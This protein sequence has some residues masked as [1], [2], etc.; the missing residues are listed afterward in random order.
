MNF[1]DKVRSI[2]VP[3]GHHLM[4]IMSHHGDK[5]EIWNPNNTDEVASAKA[6][7]DALTKKGYAAFKV[8]DKGEKGEQIHAFDPNAG[9]MI[10]APAMKGG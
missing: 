9:K 8:D 6:A 1:E 3:Q 4:I 5:K 10:L 2:E 7:F